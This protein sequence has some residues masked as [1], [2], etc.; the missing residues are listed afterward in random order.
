MATSKQTERNHRMLQ[1]ALNEFC[2]KG[3]RGASID[4]IAKRAQVSKATLYHHFDNKENLFLA[5][6]EFSMNK[7]DQNVLKGPFLES[8]NPREKI[9]ASIRLFMRELIENPEFHFFFKAFTIDID[10]ISESLRRKAIKRFFSSGFFFSRQQIRREQEFGDTKPHFHPEIIFN[11]ALGMIRHVLTWWENSGRKIS[12]AH[13]ADQVTE[14]LL[15]G[16]SKGGN[17]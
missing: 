12:L 8:P 1:A 15:F 6:F 14:I 9:K 16:T 13:C 17:A 2:Q 4:L 5:V 3:Y 10:L 7:A 11:G